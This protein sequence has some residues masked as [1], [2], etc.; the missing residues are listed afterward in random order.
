VTQ[1]NV[2]DFVSRA[3]GAPPI[4]IAETAAALVPPGARLLGVIPLP[5]TGTAMAIVAHFIPAPR[6]PEPARPAAGAG[7]V[8]DRESRRVWSDGEQI[9]LT[10]LEFELL[11]QLTAAPARVFTRDQLLVTTWG[12]V[13]AIATRTIDVHMH[14][15]RRKLGENGRDLVTVR[16]VGYKYDPGVR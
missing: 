4:E 12:G 16:S 7:L 8:I 5:D 10:Y 14:R 15:L 2:V 11:A 13:P 1:S 6:E 3:S 9:E